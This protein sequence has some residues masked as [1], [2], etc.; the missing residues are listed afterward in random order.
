MAFR[1][2]IDHGI[3]A[4]LG[5]QAGDQGLVADVAGHEDVVRV[6]PQRR[7]RV[8][9]A[10]VGQR[11]EVDDAH[12]VSDGLEDEVAPDETGSAGD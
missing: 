4:M 6:V 5:E 1:R 8:A 12:A 10:G 2:E 9:V 3:R 11:I 7:Q